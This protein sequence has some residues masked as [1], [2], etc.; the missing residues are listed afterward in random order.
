VSVLDADDAFIALLIAA[1]DAS[2]HVSAE[3]AARAHKHHLVD[4]ALS[5]S[6]R[7]TNRSQD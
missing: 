1:M 5:P 3:E 2:G 7:R 4:T 6:F